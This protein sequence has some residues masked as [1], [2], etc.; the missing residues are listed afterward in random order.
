[1]V[2]YTI[3]VDDEGR[4]FLTSPKFVELLSSYGGTG[5]AERLMARNEWNQVEEW[6]YSPRLDGTTSISCVIETSYDY[7]FDTDL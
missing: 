7:S 2:R 1:M 5:T 3:E 4:V 6:D